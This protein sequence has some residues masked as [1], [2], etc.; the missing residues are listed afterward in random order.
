MPPLLQEQKPVPPAARV[1]LDAAERALQHPGQIR[2][3]HLPLT[4]DLHLRLPMIRSSMRQQK[5]IRRHLHLSHWYSPPPRSR[6][7]PIH[8]LLLLTPSHPTTPRKIRNQH[9]RA[10]SS[11]YPEAARDFVEETEEPGTEKR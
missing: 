2:N 9:Q 1:N 6:S 5:P 10:S 4:V 7:Y 3:Q 8:Q 11:W